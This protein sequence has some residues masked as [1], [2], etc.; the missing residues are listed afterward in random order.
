MR[1]E[2]PRPDFVRREWRSLNGSWR[3]CEGDRVEEGLSKKI[4]VPF[5]PQ[6]ASSG[7]GRALTSNQI[8]YQRQ[9]QVPAQWR[10]KRILLHFGAV[11]YQCSVSLNGHRLG[12]HR[13]GQTPF[14]F[15]ITDC[16]VW[17]EELLT[18]QVTDDLNDECQ[19]RGKQ[20][21]G[22]K[23]SFIWYTQCSGIW[24][25]VWLEPVS[26]VHFESIRFTPDIDDGTVDISWQTSVYLPP[27]GWLELEISFGG[28]IVY[29]GK[30]SCGGKRGRIVVDLFQNRALRGS[31]HFTGWYWSPEHPALFDVSAR[32]VIGGVCSDEVRTYFG[33]RKIHVRDGKVFLNNQPYY[34][35]LVLDQGFWKDGLITAPSEQAYIGDIQNAKA[36]GFNGCRKHEKAEDP[37]FLYW[38]DRLG[39]LVWESTAS[40]WSFTLDGAAAFAREWSEIILRDYNHP[41]IV[42]WNMMNESWGAPRLY[43]NE[44]QQHFARSLYHM[45][46]GLDSTRLAIAND[47][48]ELTEN[49]I[50][51]LHTYK[52]GGRDDPRQQELFRSGIAHLPGLGR[53]VERPLFAKGFDYQG[54]P[55]M[56][57][58]IGGISIRKGPDKESEAA[59]TGW[60]YTG[61]DS[62][63]DF[64]E[65]YRR[66]IGQIYDSQ[67]LCG[68]CYT[69]LADIQQEQNGLLDEDH[70][71]KLDTAEIKAIND[72]MAAT[73][74]FYIDIEE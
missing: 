73:N 67:L 46:K 68:F 21:W 58:E 20:F 36:M 65:C 50:C 69:Q 48:W 54:Q 53:L 7:I 6:S 39:F 24:Q 72:R 27:S 59:G 52:H 47:G 62:V 25:S 57:T 22:E 42:V 12:E 23:G 70:R 40:F 8:S 71:P 60:G 30:T 35:K 33:M 63:A 56:L 26:P 66:L 37:V 51:A 10:G 32:L 15:D 38:A 19:P 31:F 1:S 11:D 3:F 28:E 45:A 61:A 74:A 34:Q 49:D 9:F 17:G 14:Q 16:L 4:Q 64:L 29:Q 2:Y 55:V 5:V 18:V 13:G 41:C 43:D 44:Q